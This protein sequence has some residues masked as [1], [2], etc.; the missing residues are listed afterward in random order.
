MVILQIGLSCYRGLWNCSENQFLHTHSAAW[1]RLVGSGG[2][3]IGERRSTDGAVGAVF[4]FAVEDESEVEAGRSADSAGG[5]ACE[6][7]RT[8][9]PHGDCQSQTV[10]SSQHEVG[11][12]SA[13]Q[14]SLEVPETGGA[15]APPSMSKQQQAATSGSGVARTKIAARATTVRAV[16]IVKY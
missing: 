7:G 11:S 6:V 4:S 8:E 10:A 2:W 12:V 5:T 1:R 3:S 16:L 13:L 14:H 9:H 15:H